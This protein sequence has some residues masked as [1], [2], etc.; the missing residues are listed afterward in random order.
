MTDM[1]E[2]TEMTDMTDMTD[3]TDPNCIIKAFQK[4]N[5]LILK[6]KNKY[7]FR[8]SDIANALGITNIRSSIQNYND[9]EKGVRK[10]DT[11]GGPQD[12]IFLSSH[13]IYRLLYS[14]KKKEAEEFR[15]WVGDILDD[16]IFNESKEL[17]K[18]L[19]EYENLLEQREQQLIEQEKNTKE[20]LVQKDKQKEIEK[21]ELLNNYSKL[22]LKESLKIKKLEFE[23][24]KEKTKQRELELKILQLN[25]KLD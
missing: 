17:T 20:Q 18:Q 8:G 21:M 2:M 3:I 24:Q 9:K 11:L 16:I 6:D 23:I 5:I 25:G 7:F 10:V 15:A 14:S 12:I 22:E 13:G 19:K 1:T 4:N